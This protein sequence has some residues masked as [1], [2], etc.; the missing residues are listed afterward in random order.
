MRDCFNRNI[1]I[2]F[3]IVAATAH[4]CRAQTGACSRPAVERAAGE[5]A[6]SRKTLLGVPVS[7][8]AS[9]NEQV[10]PVA[11]RAI[12]QMKDRLNDLVVAYMSCLSVQNRADP[13]RIQRDL[14]SLTHA[15]GKPASTENL[16]EVRA[17]PDARRLISMTAK[18]EIP[19]V[20]DTVLWI[21]SPSKEAWREVLRWQSKPYK[22]IDGAF[23]EFQYRISPPDRAGNWFVATSYV[24]GWG[25]S[26]WSYI[27]YGILRVGSVPSK[28]KVLLARSDFMTW[29][30]ENYGHLTAN[31]DD[32]E[33][34][35]DGASIA[36]DVLVRTYIRHYAIEGDSVARI[37]PVAVSA[38]D[39]VDEW[40]ISK[41]ADAQAWSAAANLQ[42][43]QLKHEVL[44]KLYNDPKSG[45]LAYDIILRCTDAAGV[46]QVSV[47]PYQGADFYFRVGTQPSLTMMS[48]K[49][50]PD[51]DCKGRNLLEDMATKKSSEAWSDTTTASHAGKLDSEAGRLRVP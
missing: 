25:A 1:W 31:R 6:D 23:W 42:A 40:M 9:E 26:V 22:A 21:F 29:G 32:S 14:S 16:F 44:S 20:D 43:L 8:D 19:D 4:P 2:A 49:D 33:L 28:P 18:F 37:A 36:P 5:V 46:F 34:R 38:R 24:N 47:F 35:F 48:V 45:F 12:S 13:E 30:F 11:A 39:F 3:L 50:T 7:K 10:S 27:N 41:W 17:T 51:S 15:Y